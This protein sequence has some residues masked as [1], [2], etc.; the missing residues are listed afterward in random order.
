MFRLYRVAAET[1]D[2]QTQ[3]I[4]NFAIPAALTLQSPAS[5]C[6]AAPRKKTP[7]LVSAI[8]AGN[9]WQVFVRN[10]QAEFCSQLRGPARIRVPT[11]CS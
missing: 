7:P 10:D 8:V 2:R 4:R 1:A 3:P 6:L 5:V 9:H 11:F